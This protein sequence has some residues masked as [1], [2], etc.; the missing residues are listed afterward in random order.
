[1]PRCLI[2]ALCLLLPFAAHAQEVPAEAERDMW[3]GTAFAIL[4]RD[5]PADATPEEEAAAGYFA[6]GG[7]ALVERALPIYFES[8]YSDAALQHYRE[9]LEARLARLFASGGR[10]LEDARYSFEECRALIGP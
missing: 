1:M 2:F 9:T 8:G 7:E 4:A 10:S 3:C 6:D 5:L